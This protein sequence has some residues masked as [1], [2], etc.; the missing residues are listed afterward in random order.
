MARLV[1]F[2]TSNQN[3]SGRLL[4]QTISYHTG[5]SGELWLAKSRINPIASYSAADQLGHRTLS[6]EAHTG[7]SLAKHSQTSLFH[8]WLDLRS[9]LSLR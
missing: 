2:T 8:F 6:G 3:R 7:P 1:V 4:A 9:S 5:L